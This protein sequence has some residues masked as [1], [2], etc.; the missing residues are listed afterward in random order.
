MLNSI[1]KLQCLRDTLNTELSTRILNEVIADISQRDELGH[2]D[3]R[4]FDGSGSLPT[5]KKTKFL[6]AS[7]D[8]AITED[9]RISLEYYLDLLIEKNG[10]IDVKGVAFGSGMT[11]SILDTESDTRL[12]QLAASIEKQA[13]ATQQAVSMIAALLDVMAGDEDEAQ[14]PTHL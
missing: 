14:A 13:E 12:T 1:E 5:T 6:V 3:T 2:L 8:A 4:S 7:I 9:S 10:L 11:L